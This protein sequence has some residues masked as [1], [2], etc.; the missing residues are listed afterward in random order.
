MNELGYRGYPEK[1]E[2]SAN[3]SALQPIFLETHLNW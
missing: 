2:C 1:S 3:E